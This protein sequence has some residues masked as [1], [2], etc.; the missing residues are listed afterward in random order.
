M[1]RPQQCIALFTHFARCIL[2]HFHAN[3]IFCWNQA[4]ELEVSS[5]TL[6]LTFILNRVIFFSN[7]LNSLF[8]FTLEKPQ[9]DKYSPDEIK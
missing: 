3:A 6:S 7:T 2:E 9:G 1:L 4:L 8:L 5:D